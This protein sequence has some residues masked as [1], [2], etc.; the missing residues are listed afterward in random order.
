MEIDVRILNT[1]M[2]FYS[3]AIT[4]PLP[5][6]ASIIGLSKTLGNYEIIYLLIF[7]I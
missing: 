4:K 2:P 5:I 7:N 1:T 6:R 3:S